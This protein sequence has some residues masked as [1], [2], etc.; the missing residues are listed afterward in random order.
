M[1]EER[2]TPNLPSRDFEATAAFY[3][4][5]GFEE[6]FRDGGWMILRRG[7]FQLEFFPY[8][9]L[10]PAESSFSCCLRMADVGTFADEIAAAERRRVGRACIP[11]GANIGAGSSAR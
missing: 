3:A 2:A 5:L 10:E 4:R 7:G 11:R 1:I 6:G 9:D 8:P